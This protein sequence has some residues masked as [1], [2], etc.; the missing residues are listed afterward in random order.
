[1]SMFIANVLLALLWSLMFGEFTPQNFLIGMVV[2]FVALRLGT[3]GMARATYFRKISTTISFIFYFLAQLVIAN[4]KMAAYTLGSTRQ[5][6]PGILA[7]PLTEGMT[8]L[9]ITVLAN[10]IT[11]TPGTLSMDV[12][13]DKTTLYVHYIHVEDKDEAVREI[14]DGFERRL[15]ALTR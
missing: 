14:K 13:D 2:G 9:E 11:L 6:R 4:F 5:L 8:D 7:I 10:V 12:S 3:V 1:M 15:L